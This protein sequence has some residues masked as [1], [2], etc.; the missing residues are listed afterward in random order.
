MKKINLLT[1]SLLAFFLNSAYAEITLESK[2]EV[3][4]TWKLQYTKNSLNDKEAI[5]RE[6]TWIFKDGKATILH[7]PR[8][9]K[10]YDQPPVN[11]EIE[12]GK[13]KIALVGNGR[14]DIFSL[15]EKDDKS[16]TL[17][18]KF[19]GYYYFTKK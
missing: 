8:D 15:E 19:G 5:N 10:Y 6:D 11:Y 2:S 12:N 13:L 18:G 7:I 1:I 4:G 16:M 9:G 17:K 3:E 14:F